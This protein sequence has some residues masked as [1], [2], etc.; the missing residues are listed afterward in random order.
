MFKSG[1]IVY[2]DELYFEDKIL[3]SKYKRPCVVLYEIEIDGIKYVCTC[4]LTSQIK[5]FNK[6]PQN[7]V[8]IPTVIYNYR[9]VLLI[10][11]IQD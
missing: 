1:E 11:Q 2:H 4:P 3:D 7:Y 6:K 9:K 8:L 5:T 10:Y